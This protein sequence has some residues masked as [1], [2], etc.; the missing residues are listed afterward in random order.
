M[1][2]WVRPGNF[3]FP[4]SPSTPVIMVGPG[5]GVAPF[6]AAIQER[7]ARGQKGEHTAGRGLVLSLVGPSDASPFPAL[8]GSFLFFGCRRRNQDFYWEAEWRVLE[9]SGFLTLVTA[10]SREQVGARG[11]G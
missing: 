5:T 7:V 6:R 4:D 8:P 2:L 11:H 3:T 1:P 10:F 9:E